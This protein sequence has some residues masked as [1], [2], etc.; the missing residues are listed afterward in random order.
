MKETILP[1]LKNHGKCRHPRFLMISALFSLASITA[2]AQSVVTGKVTDETGAGMP[3]VNIII[4][5]TTTGTTSDVNGDYS[6]SVG[7]NEQLPLVF[8]FIG[9]E[10]HEELIAGR[11]VIN[12]GLV[13]SVESLTEVVVVGYGTQKKSDVTGAISSVDNRTIREIPAQDVSNALQGRVAGVDIQRT[14]SKPGGDS[15]IR[16]RGNRSLGSPDGDNN[17]PLIVLDGIPYLGSLTSINQGDIESVDILKDASATAIYG[18]RGSNG[19]IIITTRKGK[20]GQSRVS[21]NG[22]HGISTPL[23]KYDV[24]SGEEFAAYV[25]EAGTN[26]LT[27]DE[28]ESISQGREV[29]WQDLVFGNGYKSNHEVSFS[30]G[31]EN[32]QYLASGNYFKETNAMPGQAFTRY[33]LRLNLDHQASER[34]KIGMN[35]FTTYS[36]RDGEGTTPGGLL[37]FSPLTKPYTD[38][39]EVNENFYAGHIDEPFNINPLVYFD[40]SAWEEQRKRLTSFT[41]MYGEVEIIEGLRYRLNVGLDLSFDKRGQFRGS[42]L[43]VSD[44]N[45][46]FVENAHSWSYTLEN[47]LLFDRTFAERHSINFTGLFSVQENEWARQVFFTSDLASDQLQYYNLSLGG[48]VLADN[49]QGGDDQQYTKWGLLSYMARINYNYDERYIL[50]LTARTDG[51]SRLAEGNKWFT[52][53]AAALAWNIHNESF[54]RGVDAFSNLRFRAGW[55]RTSNQAISPYQSL[56]RLSDIT[57]SYGP[58]GGELGYFAS[59]LPNPNLTWEFTST[60]NV[61]FDFGLLTNRINA[62]VELYKSETSDILQNRSLPIM[63]GVSG[64]FQQNV[65]KTENKGLELTLNALAIEPQQADGFRWELDLNFTTWSEEIVQLYDTLKQDINN[66]WFVGHPI[67]VVYDYKKT[68][69]WQLGEEDE[70][71]DFDGALEPG[72]IRVA[73]LNGNG[74]RDEGDRS[75]LGALKPDWMG[76]LT[77]RWSYKGVDLSVVLFARAGGLVVSR[78]HQ[79]ASLEGRRNQV[80]VDYWTPENPTN[81]Y[82]K[83]GDQFPQFRSTMGYFDGTYMKIRTISLGYTLPTSLLD[84]VGINSARVYFTAENPF[85]AFFSDLVDAGIV[86]PESNARGATETPGYG[87]RLSVNYDSPL[88]KSFI[89]GLNFDF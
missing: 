16:I 87:Q 18:S 17:D 88:M 12:V 35:T 43:N 36:L 52:Y 44:A 71:T 1:R 84:R 45:S 55:G 89:F 66:G 7:D 41:S 28:M 61:G 65:G 54:M 5:N 23:G 83:T 59:N 20:A 62:S 4:K 75:V 47:L 3:G 77:S 10:T 34:I 25:E 68:G 33:S 29:D 82:P 24:F 21:Y 2:Y 26:P 31:S 46:A 14:S 81:A 22:F 80:E 63:S 39:G 73:D 13:L 56:G 53:P 67:D 79:D 51:S 8:S 72:D 60:Y 32:T 9:Y 48:T 57:Y 70:A 69:V 38:D 50:T 11:S 74:V 30:G 58:D 37:S 64:T 6:I 15:Q 42:R 86:D 40:E 19:V 76:G 85:K 27:A 78:I 49:Q